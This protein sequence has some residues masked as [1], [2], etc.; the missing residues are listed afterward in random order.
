MT[1]APPGAAAGDRLRWVIAALGLLAVYVALSL[2]MDPHGYLGTDTGTKVATLE[3]MDRA[4]TA[5]PD[6]GYWA[7]RWDPAGDLHPLRDA[8][9]VDGHWVAVTTLPVLEAARPL[10]ALAGYRGSLLLPM[11]GAV[12]A[13]GAAAVLA[14]RVGADRRGR[15][16]AFWATGLASPLLVYALDFWEHSIGVALVAWSALLLDDVAGGRRAPLWAALAGAGFAA[17]A[18]LRNE[19][20]VYGAVTLLA[21]VW[22]WARRRRGGDR[23]VPA[24][25]RS[26][27]AWTVGFA[28]VFGANAWLEDALAGQS[29][30]ERASSTAAE[31]GSGLPDRVREAAVTLTGFKGD[32]WAAAAFGAV[33]VAAL[34]AAVVALRRGRL[35]EGRAVRAVA[36]LAAVMAVAGLVRPSFVPGLLVAYPLAAV[37][38]FGR[39]GGS[40]PSAGRAPRRWWAWAVGALPVVWAFQYLGG[41]G[42]QWGGRYTLPSALVL[43]VLGVAGLRDLPVAATRAMLA[44]SVVVTATGAYWLHVRSHEV[45]RFFDDVDALDGDVVVARDEFVL[46]EAGPRLLD[47]HWLRAGDESAYRRAADLALRSGARTLVVLDPAGVPPDPGPRWRLDGRLALELVDDEVVAARYRRSG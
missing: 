11:A 12:A 28:A 7:Q 33:L 36:G 30:G 46:R 15:W 26:A 20:L 40:G 47:R 27:V 32:T 5:R 25:V 41:A 39:L 14:G 8:T 17:A 29:R 21:A 45:P 4:G 16:V 3:A 19:A 31:A 24:L 2:L 23:V 22:V 38:L 1:A 9:L 13:A 44:L 42:P 35:D 37:G 6:V 18:T 10:Y 34:A 43:G